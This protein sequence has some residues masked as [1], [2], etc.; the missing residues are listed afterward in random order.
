[1]NNELARLTG[2]V[3]SIMTIHGDIVQESQTRLLFAVLLLHVSEL[4]LRVILLVEM[5]LEWHKSFS[6]F[7]E[8]QLEDVG[9]RVSNSRTYMV[10]K[11][12]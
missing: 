9:G 10:F 7:G 2:I 4:T 12:N 6:F 8:N 1:M 3:A 5:P 11:A